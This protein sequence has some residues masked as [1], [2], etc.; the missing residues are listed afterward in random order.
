MKVS[1]LSS[2]LSNNCL[3]RAL[4]LAKVLARRYEVEMIGP[5]FG[6]EIWPPYDR[7]EFP[8][9]V[10]RGLSPNELWSSLRPALRAIEGD[11]VYAVKPLLASY[12]VA[13][14]KK[15]VSKTPVVLDIDD[16]QLG[17]TTKM[18]GW[19][20]L[21][22]VRARISGF[23]TAPNSYYWVALMEKLV[24][25]ADDITTVSSFLN[26]RF[27]G[28]GAIVPHGR[29]A[30]VFDPRLYDAEAL[31]REHG[32]DHARVIM[33]LGTPKP[34]KGIEDIVGAVRS[35][36]RS[37]VRI[38][39]VGVAPEERFVH[40]LHE[41]HGD[42]I[43]PF[44]MIPFSEI[45]RFLCMADLVVLPQKRDARTVGQ[46]PAK[47]IDAMAMAKPI[48]ATNVSDMAS[49]L[50]G[51][52]LVAEPD[53]VNDLAS[54]I[55][56]LLDDRALGERLG[57]RAREKFLGELSFDVMERRLLDTFGKYEHRG[58]RGRQAR[59]IGA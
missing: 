21:A 37:D 30:S 15:L 45:P 44:P 2:N 47:L 32:L 8:T 25:L 41:R 40:G 3:G 13:L 6:K 48:I 5:T 18:D 9:K 52:G 31:R 28:R 24:P 39:I 29:D 17:F 43:V 27:G 46:I 57:E 34:H 26:E 22:R 1:I 23:R 20:D 16:W 36:D 33:F 35:L 50:D 10:L 4:I 56:L 49:M 55:A 58:S 12:G 42:L 11:V 38:V 14:A 19:L 54:K 59:A 51:C 7:N 53:D